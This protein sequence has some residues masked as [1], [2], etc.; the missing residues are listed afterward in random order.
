VLWYF[1]EVDSFDCKRGKG[2][3][4]LVNGFFGLNWVVACKVFVLYI[5]LGEYK[6][7]RDFISVGDLECSTI[8]AGS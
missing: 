4:E 2:V 3:C 7:L 5:P 8:F 6:T 1:D